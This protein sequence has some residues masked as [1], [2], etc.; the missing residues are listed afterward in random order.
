MLTSVTACFLF[1]TNAQV[2]SS[3][4]TAE[5]EV[6]FTIRNFG[7]NVEG[8]LSGLSGEIVFDGASPAKSR[9]DVSVKAS[10]INTGNRMR[11]DHLRKKEYLDV[12]RHPDI[13]FRSVSIAAGR[14]TGSYTVRGLLT[15]KGI[16]REVSFPFRAEKKASAYLFTGSFQINRQ[17]YGVG[18]GSISLSD[19]LTISLRINS[20]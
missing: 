11:D 4:A 8:T 13:R 18:G 20:R 12:E 19:Q 10:T 17:D 1:H 3:P 5:S 7:L 14:E 6:R 16:S 15:I 2:L 9:F